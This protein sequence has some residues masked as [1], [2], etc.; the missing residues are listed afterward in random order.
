LP[1]LVRQSQANQDPD[2]EEQLVDAVA[3]INSLSLAIASPDQKNNYDAAKEQAA[4]YGWSLLSQRAANFNR[5]PTPDAAEALASLYKV[6][7]IFPSGQLAATQQNLLDQGKAA[8]AELSASDSRITAMLAAASDWTSQGPGGG[9]SVLAARQAITPFDEARFDATDRA[10]WETLGRAQAI[11]QGPSLGLNKA[12]MNQVTLYVQP[13]DGSTT[14]TEIANTIADRLS[15]AG[16][17]V[18]QS[19]GDAA[20]IVKAMIMSQTE[21]TQD[22]SSGYLEMTSSATLALTATW[23]A[24]NSILLST[25]VGGV[26]QANLNGGDAKT[27]ALIDAV[28]AIVSKFS[29][30]T[31]R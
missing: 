10:A 4:S 25:T 5:N 3:S 13:S 26:G 31:S 8:T 29:D 19:P 11:I 2:A 12:T 18:V 9:N 7:T 1:A 27:E 23:T 6:L 24:D 15:D 17:H 30:M 21:P 20:V 28:S 22:L 16:F 14:E